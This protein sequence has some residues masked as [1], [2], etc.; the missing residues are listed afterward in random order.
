MDQQGPLLA[1]NRKELAITSLEGRNRSQL[2]RLLTVLVR[3]RRDPPPPLLVSPEDA[4][5]AVRAA[6]LVKAVTPEL[7]RRARVYAS[8]ARDISRQ[9]RLAAV[10]SATEFSAESRAADDDVAAPVATVA[11]ITGETGQLEL[12]AP[13]RLLSPLEGR[14]VQ[15]FGA[16]LV[17]GG[18][19]SGLTLASQAGVPVYAP[20]R[21]LVQFSGPVKGWGTV[22]I[23]R[24]TGGY[25]LVLAGLGTPATDPGEDIMPGSKIGLMP[26]G[27]SGAPQ[28]YM[29]MR[30]G[31]TPVDPAPLLKSPAG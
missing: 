12:I 25:H 16:D 13:K 15:G 23:L 18:K 26:D 8:E 31:S 11:M 22:I 9:R 2:A 3:L 24:L 5:A 7:Q 21:G 30:A 1:L 6:I 20:A 27:R 17:T 19:S 14:I 4:I 29:E 28:L 10:A